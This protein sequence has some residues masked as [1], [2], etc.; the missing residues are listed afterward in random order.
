[1]RKTTL[2]S[3]V[4]LQT[5]A[6]WTFVSLRPLSIN[7]MKWE[8]YSVYEWQRALSP[9]SPPHIWMEYWHSLF[10]F[11]VSVVNKKVII[12]F[13]FEELNEIM[14]I[15]VVGS[16]HTWDGTVFPSTVL[17]ERGLKG[18]PGYGFITALSK[19]W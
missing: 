17:C 18:C 9:F 2:Q 15:K 8:N 1:M 19:H 12:I 16:Q 11:V 3:S 10:L 14:V 6:I 5:D 13:I 4:N 7:P